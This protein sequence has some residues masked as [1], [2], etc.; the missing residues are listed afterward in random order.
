MRISS[1]WSN[2]GWS[3]SPPAKNDRTLVGGVRGCGGVGGGGGRPAPRVG[4]TP[5]SPPPPGGAPRGGGVGAPPPPPPAPN[6]A[7]LQQASP[8][9]ISQKT[10]PLHGCLG[11]RP[12]TGNE[13]S[14]FGRRPFGSYFVLRFERRPLSA[15]LGREMVCGSAPISISKDL[16]RSSLVSVAGLWRRC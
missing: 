15:R 10:G 5:P 2:P 7:E 9:R 8:P 11:Q 1:V 12:R 13:R 4:V 3:N 14:S 6:A 16:R